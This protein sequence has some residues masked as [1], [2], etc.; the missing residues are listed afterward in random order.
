MGQR[1]SCTNSFLEVEGRFVDNPAHQPD[2]YKVDEYTL[3]GSSAALL[4]LAG[5]ASKDRWVTVNTSNGVV[6]IVQGADW[7]DSVGSMVCRGVVATASEVERI[8]QR[9][10]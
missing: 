8:R 7:V 9:T 2:G 4:R 10:Q 6:V 1:V 3:P 5:T